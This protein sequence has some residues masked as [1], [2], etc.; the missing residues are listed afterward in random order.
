MILLLHA[1][2][3][4]VPEPSDGSG[5]PAAAPPDRVEEG[6]G[7]VCDDPGARAAAP[8][9]AYAWE[10]LVDASEANFQVQYGGGGAAVADFDGDGVLDLVLPNAGADQYWQG[11]PGGGWA[12]ETAARWPGGEADATVGAVPADVDADGDLDVFV[13]N[14]RGPNRL[15]INDGGGRFTDGT[16]AAGVAGG[17]TD[18]ISASFADIDADG[19]LDLFVANHRDDETIPDGMAAGE[20]LPGHPSN[21]YL[22]DGA[23]TFSDVSARLPPALQDNGY[24]FVGAFHD[25]DGDDLPELYIAMDFGPMSSPN[26]LLHNDGG[27]FS[28]VPDTGLDHTGYAMGLALGDIDDD[29]QIDVAISDWSRM[30]LLMAAADGTWY[31]AALAH[32]IMPVAEG[33]AES[34]GLELADMDNDGDL[35]LPVAFGPLLMPPEIEEDY[36]QTWAL[37]NPDDQPDALFVLGDDGTFRDES[38]AWGLAQTGNSR[39]FVLADL[40]GDGYLDVLKRFVNEVASIHLSR[41]G[42]GAWLR[43]ELRQDGM[44]P[45]AVGATV[46]IEAAG[47]TWTRQLRG[48]GTGFASGQPPEIHVGLGDIDAIDSIRVRWPDGGET[49]TEALSARQAIRIWR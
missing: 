39:G 42:D 43:V 19:D 44:N 35:D 8:M 2:A 26:L 32:G 18:S 22:N 15:L 5:K 16:A 31:D 34:W 47:R 25:F 17:V 14:M 40:D 36:A 11:L 13:T 21:L 27:T 33:R 48:G 4:Y 38:A 30:A 49:V 46:T 24:P 10:G 37:Q 28:V 12:D 45:R 23:G 9:D 3:C 6:G 7:V 29:G 1:L 41:C 20:M